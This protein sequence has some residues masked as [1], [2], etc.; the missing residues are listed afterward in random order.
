MH[1]NRGIKYS[2]D[3]RNLLKKLVAAGKNITEIRNECEKFKE[4]FKPTNTIIQNYRS[5]L[6][7][8]IYDL[9]E[10]GE[11]TALNSGL[12][13]RENRVRALTRLAHRMEFDLFGEELIWLDDA[14]TVA[15]Q[16]FD[17]KQFNKAQIDV[18]LRILDDI[19]KEIGGRVQRVEVE[20]R[21]Y[22]IDPAPEPVKD[23]ADKN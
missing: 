16:R 18:Y 2:M 10:K 12:A 23:G 1:N 19:S 15:S 11:F 21:T 9:I 14:K 7:V 6:G 4:P 5:A 3:Q 8:K 22:V 17:F 13:L 20:Q